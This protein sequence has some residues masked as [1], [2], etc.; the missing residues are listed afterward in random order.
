MP[1]DKRTRATL[2]KAEFGF[3]GVAVYT[4]IQTPLLWGQF[5]NAGDFPLRFLA[6]RLYLTN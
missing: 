1:L 3:L 2:R 5:P 6:F 4:L